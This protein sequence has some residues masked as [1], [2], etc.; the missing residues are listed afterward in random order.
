MPDRASLLESLR[1]LHDEMTKAR[2]Q[3]DLDE[4]A[5]TER[6]G[7]YEAESRHK[8]F[9]V[10]SYARRQFRD[11]RTF[12]LELQRRLRGHEDRLRRY[13]VTDGEAALEAVKQ[14]DYAVKLK[15]ELQIAEMEK[16]EIRL[17]VEAEVAQEHRRI[18]TLLDERAK[19]EEAEVVEHSYLRNQGAQQERLEK[20]VKRLTGKIDEV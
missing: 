10:E 4:Q 19:V 16:S 5:E 9:E 6:L 18:S 8:L 11:E 15:A 20:T 3:R 2:K 7:N 17:S 12:G 1:E 13:H 14:K